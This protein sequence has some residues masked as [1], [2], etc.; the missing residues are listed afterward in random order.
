MTLNEKEVLDMWW[1]QLGHYEYE[2]S[3]TF[4]LQYTGWYRCING[5]MADGRWPAWNYN[6]GETRY[7]L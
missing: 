4:T 5:R 3:E 7:D 1:Q 6:T 2:V